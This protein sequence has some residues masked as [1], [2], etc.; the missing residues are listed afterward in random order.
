MKFGITKMMNWTQL[1]SQEGL[2]EI[3]TLSFQQPV[4]IFK[5]STRCS[6]SSTALNR[7]ERSWN[8]S[9]MQGIKAFFLDLITYRPISNQIANDFKVEHESPQLLLIR[10]GACVYHNSH[11]GISYTELK[12]QLETIKV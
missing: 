9:E 8:V 12:K 7:L 5:H 6:I 1:N 10:N 2:E 11:M 3:K 4:M